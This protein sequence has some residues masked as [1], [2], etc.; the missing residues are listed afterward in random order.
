MRAP[1]NDADLEFQL[2]ARGKLLWPLRQK[3]VR[4]MEIA[5]NKSLPSLT[6]PNSH[7]ECC[8]SVGIDAIHSTR[9]QLF[10]VS[11]VIRD[12]S[13]IPLLLFVVRARF[14]KLH[15][16]LNYIIDSAITIIYF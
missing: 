10:I 13:I 15:K 3:A 11:S 4:A 8:I 14:S 2:R 12:A 9:S 7:Y 5:R 1:L 6:A 16:W